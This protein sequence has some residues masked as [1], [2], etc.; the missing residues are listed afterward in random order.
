MS[1]PHLFIHDVVPAWLDAINRNVHI[2]S[3]LEHLGIAESLEEKPGNTLV[4]P[5]PLHHGREKNEFYV[6]NNWNTWP[7][8]GACHRGGTSLDFVAL[9]EGVSYPVAA[10]LLQSW[11]QLDLEKLELVGHEN[12]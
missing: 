7:C 2:L 8:Y 12:L 9:R 4:G 3:L 5:C 11:Y 1:A 6:Y 10:L